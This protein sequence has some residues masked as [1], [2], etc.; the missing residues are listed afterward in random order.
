[1]TVTIRPAAPEDVHAV[2]FVGFVTWPSTYG[3]RN[4]AEFVVSGLDAY[5]SADAIT[6]AID[7]GY[8]EVAETSEGIVGMTHVEPLGD[9]LVMWKLYVLPNRQHGGVGRALVDSAKARA[10]LHGGDLLTEYE[11]SNE[12][13]RGFYERQGFATTS[14]P[15]PDTN[16]VWLRWSSAPQSNEAPR[17]T[18]E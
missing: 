7:S 18:N 16:A 5:W 15:W 1:M 6:G 12:V 9:D 17:S 14:A 11:P 13:V 10:R 8:I 4:G 2:R 3:P